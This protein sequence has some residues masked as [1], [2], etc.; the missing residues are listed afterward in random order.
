MGKKRKEILFRKF[1]KNLQFVR[2]QLGVDFE[3]R[4]Q[5]EA[6]ICPLSFQIHTKDGIQD[7][8][9]DQLTEEHIPPDSLGGKVMCL[10][11]KAAN[12]E[13]GHLLDNKLLDYIQWIE[14]KAGL[15]EYK[16][17]FKFESGGSSP[18]FISKPGKNR[19]LLRFQ[20]SS[21]HPGVEKVLGQI[22]N[23][24]KFSGKVFLPHKKQSRLIQIGL[25]RI[26]YLYAFSTLGYSYLFG[27]SR[28]VKST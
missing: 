26:A 17:K 6:Y 23:E 27:G 4:F 7:R 21:F 19:P 9:S 5:E 13:S 25:L 20:P 16:T 15:G 12:S 2:K 1:S 3:Q 10:T 11:S 22:E 28:I 8:F 24:K 18:L 14:A